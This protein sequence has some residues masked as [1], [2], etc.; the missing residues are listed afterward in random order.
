MDPIKINVE[1]SIK[2]DSLQAL[3][4]IFTTCIGGAAPVRPTLPPKPAEAPKAETKA[5]EAPV[6]PAAPAAPA[7][8]NMTLNAEVKAAQSRGVDK[9]RILEV[10]GK[11]GIKS[12]RECPEDKRPALLA[13]L[14]AL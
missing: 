14:K 3:K 1:L 6:A 7:I 9:A 5:P 11:Y 12:S 13:D 10:F 4:N 8:D 2:D